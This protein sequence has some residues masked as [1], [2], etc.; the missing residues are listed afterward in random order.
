MLLRAR[1]RLLNSEI[2]GP[3][4]GA[5]GNIVNMHYVFDNLLL[6][7]CTFTNKIK[8][9]VRMSKETSTKFMLPGLRGLAGGRGSNGLSVNMHYFFTISDL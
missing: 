8:C 2:L 3:R 4:P 1:Q 7:Y 5:Y 6:V 9:M